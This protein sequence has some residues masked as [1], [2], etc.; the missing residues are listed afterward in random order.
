MSATTV[1]KLDQGF[2]KILH[3]INHPDRS[4]SDQV[5]RL[6][7]ARRWMEEVDTGNWLL[8]LDNVFPEVLGFLREH[9][10][11]KNGRGS[12][13]FTTR[14]R[15]VAVALASAAG[16]QHDIVRVSMLNI[17]DGAELFCG[18]F[19]DGE[20][21]AP[22]DKVER[23]VKSVGC[24]PLAI[25]HTAAYMKQSTSSVDDML[26]LYESEYRIDVSMVGYCPDCL[27]TRFSCGS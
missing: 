16:K 14:T 5:V 15:N 17:Q 22:L 12:I 25:S 2:S 19:G 13:L 27:F 4:H 20:I 26:A 1:E 24:L 18:H 10:P 9:L 7:A 8:V 23:I 6:T 11:R 3:L 21:D